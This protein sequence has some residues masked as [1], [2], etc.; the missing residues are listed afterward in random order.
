VAG[1]LCRAAQNG[2]FWALPD[3]ERQF[4]GPGLSALTGG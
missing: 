2:Q 3:R 4:A 1:S